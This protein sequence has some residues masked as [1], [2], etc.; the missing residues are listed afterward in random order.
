MALQVRQIPTPENIPMT[1]GVVV[2]F[3]AAGS[4]QVDAASKRVADGIMRIA[5]AEGKAAAAA[6][7]RGQAQ[8]EANRHGG[9][10][11]VAGRVAGGFKLA[12]LIGGEAGHEFKS[13]GK[14]AGKAALF[15]AGGI[16]LAGVGLAMNALISAADEAGEKAGAFVERVQAISKKL[17]EAGR[18][19]GDQGYSF[20]TSNSL[21]IHRALTAGA[22]M[23]QIADGQRLGLS[24]ESVGNIRGMPNNGSAAAIASA[25]RQFGLD[26]NTA[27]D[28]MGKFGVGSGDPVDRAAQLAGRAQDRRISSSERT[29]A[30]RLGGLRSIDDIDNYNGEIAAAGAENVGNGRA[31]AAAKRRYDSTTDPVGAARAEIIADGND[32]SKVLLEIAK[33]TSTFVQILQEIGHTVGLSGKS[34]D[35][36]Y[37]AENAAQRKALAAAAGN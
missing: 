2:G 35:Q 8:Q 20:A 26:P 6:R 3:E 16:A 15:G 34:A 22:T 27:V 11:G 12:S 1:A 7:A 10:D 33:N 24:P 13:L 30:R 4:G 21:G 29:N 23:D 14:T 25:A 31:T 37:N 36:N 32:R 19:L 17:R 5:S 18:A 9:G 28:M